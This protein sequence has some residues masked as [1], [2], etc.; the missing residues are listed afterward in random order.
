MK[1][2]YCTFASANVDSLFRIKDRNEAVKND[3]GK[4]M[5]HLFFLADSKKIG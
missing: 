4:K 2:L 3:M 5:F 1:L